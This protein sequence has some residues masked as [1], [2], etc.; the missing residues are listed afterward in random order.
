ME[1]FERSAVE[2]PPYPFSRDKPSIIFS[3]ALVSL[4]MKCT[5]ALHIQYE[6]CHNEVFYSLVLSILTRFFCQCSVKLIDMTEETTL[7]SSGR[8]AGGNLFFGLG[9]RSTGCDLC[10]GAVS[11]GLYYT[12]PAI[13]QDTA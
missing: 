1:D 10:P 2:S 8:A 3:I 9:F 7:A 13:E 5:N 4:E 12:V 6:K 11:A